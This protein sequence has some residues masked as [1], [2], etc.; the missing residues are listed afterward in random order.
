MIPMDYK[1]FYSANDIAK[2]YETSRSSAYKI[3]R[4]IKHFV[5][6]ENNRGK[7]MQGKVL[8][9]ELMLW[10]QEALRK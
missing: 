2:R 8:G 1:V 7:L 9:I 10:E 3:I 4:E 5:D 6:A